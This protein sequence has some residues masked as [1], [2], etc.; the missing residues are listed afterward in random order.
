MG[1]FSYPKIRQCVG[2]ERTGLFGLGA[3][4][5]CLSLCV[6]SI[7]TPRSPF[8]LLGSNE[9]PT[10]EV[11]N[12]RCLNG[13]LVYTANGTSS[14]MVFYNATSDPSLGVT[15]P[16]V[17]SNSSTVCNGSTPTS[18]EETTPDISIWLL[19]VGIITARFGKTVLHTLRKLSFK[20]LNQ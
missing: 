11:S 20:S 5:L 10:P 6:V 9:I 13:S 2:L 18:S 19:M 14:V 16:S 7:W 1:A 3:E 15:L 8:D 17:L 4:I 12:T